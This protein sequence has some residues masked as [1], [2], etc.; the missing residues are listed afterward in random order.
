MQA[1]GEKTKAAVQTPGRPGL[2]LPVSNSPA[3]GR[4]CPRRPR[5][6]RHL[7]EGPALEAPLEA[8]SHPRDG[9]TDRTQCE[10]GVCELCPDAPDATLPPGRSRLILSR[11]SSA[12]CSTKASTCSSAVLSVRP[13]AFPS[14]SNMQLRDKNTTQVTRKPGH[15]LLPPHPQPVPNAPQGHRGLGSGTWSTPQPCPCGCNCSN[16]RCFHEQQGRPKRP[17]EVSRVSA[18]HQSPSKSNLMGTSLLTMSF[19]TSLE[20]E[21]KLC[22]GWRH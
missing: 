16:T 18:T 20:T 21:T 2:H 7:C 11:A 14:G 22:G 19:K 8:P 9:A 13:Q 3:K 10:P 4:A 6:P 5:I 1:P 12:A 15:V 17:L